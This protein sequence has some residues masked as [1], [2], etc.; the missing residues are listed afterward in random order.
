M[1]PKV[2]FQEDRSFYI[3]KK[4][5]WLA[6]GLVLLIIPPAALF[7]MFLYL[8]RMS[9]LF[10][11]EAALILLFLLLSPIVGMVFTLR[12]VMIQRMT[13]YKTHLPNPF[14]LGKRKIPLKEI[15]YV[16]HYIIEDGP[17]KVELRMKKRSTSTTDKDVVLGRFL[18]DDVTKMMV[19]FEKLG[20]E[21]TYR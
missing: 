6:L 10:P 13:I 14:I 20:I 4:L 19:A 3:K 9:E 11:Q 5:R 1:A 8:L 17:Q 21:T 15:E 2:Y 12:A 18:E 7:V 16:K